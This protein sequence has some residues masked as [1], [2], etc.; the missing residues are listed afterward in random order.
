[1][2]ELADWEGLA[3][4]DGSGLTMAT[5]SQN[6]GTLLVSPPLC[7][8]GSRSSQGRLSL[9]TGQARDLRTEVTCCT[10]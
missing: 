2:A 9:S 1:M 8:E 10:S 7:Q 6:K 4:I 3:G 5:R